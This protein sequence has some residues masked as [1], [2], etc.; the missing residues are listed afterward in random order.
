MEGD[1]SVTIER[2]GSND[3]RSDQG[4]EGNPEVDHIQLLEDALLR[5]TNCVELLVGDRVDR[6]GKGN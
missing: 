5:M 1:Q 3:Q 6:R 4:N 2:Q